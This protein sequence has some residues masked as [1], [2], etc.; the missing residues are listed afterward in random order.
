MNQTFAFASKA[1]K[2]RKTIRP[3]PYVIAVVSTIIATLAR[4]LLDP[5]LGEKFPYITYMFAI[6]FVAWY[7]GLLPSLLSL[8]LGFLSAFYFFC[9]PRGSVEVYGLESQVGALLYV[10]V[11]LA[12]VLFSE[13]MHASRR[14][15]DAMAAELMQ[16]KNDLEREVQERCEAQDGYVKLLRRL[17]TAQEEERRRIAQELHDQCGQDL[18][19]LDLGLKFLESGAGTSPVA[20][21]EIRALHAVV[22]RVAEEVHHLALKLRPIALDELGLCA[23]VSHSPGTLS[24]SH[25]DCSKSTG[26]LVIPLQDSK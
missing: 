12:S 9:H 21:D 5:L 1:L 25:P 17:V 3:L 2:H 18:T 14:R 22:G 20:Q 15:A 23:A 16:K 26:I 19:A 6:V 24:S 13:S 8:V 4:M 11:G 7:G 10:A